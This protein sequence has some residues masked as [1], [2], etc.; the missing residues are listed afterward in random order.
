MNQE[1]TALNE[2][3]H[4]KDC[5]FFEYDFMGGIGYMC[6]N[7]Q[8]QKYRQNVTREENCKDWEKF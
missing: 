2:H 7:K 5:I 4:C 8:G 1:K 3:P 6:M